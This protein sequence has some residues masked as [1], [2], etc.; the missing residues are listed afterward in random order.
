ML[1]DITWTIEFFPPLVLPKAPV[2]PAG[3]FNLAG[4]LVYGDARLARI[5][6]AGSRGV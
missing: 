2:S 6:A 5:G 4:A 1:L 3:V